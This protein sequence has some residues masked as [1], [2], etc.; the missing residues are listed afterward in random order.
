M[1]EVV[2]CADAEELAA[3]AADS[4]LEAIRSAVQSRGVARIALSGGTTPIGAYQKLATL[5]RDVE[6]TRWFWVDERAVP[7]DHPRSNYGL[8]QRHLLGPAGVPAAQVFRMRGEDPPEDAARDYAGVLMTQIDQRQHGANNGHP[9]WQIELDLVVAGVGDDGHTAS[10]FPNTGAVLREDRPVLVVDPAQGLE[11]RL[12][13]SRPVLLSARRTVILCAG[14]GKAAAVARALSP[15][16]ED[17]V[18]ARLYR[19]ARPGSVTWFLDRN[20][21]SNLGHSGS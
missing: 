20:A 4:M 15:G 10:L 6:H 7:P 3:R 17:E 21:A 16:D 12:T 5:L 1:T 19:A 8:A 13:L 2:E 14:A 9:G 18:P 11:R